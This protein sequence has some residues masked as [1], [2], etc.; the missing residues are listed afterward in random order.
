[1]MPSFFIA[2]GAP[3]LAIQN[4]DY[5]QFLGKLG[6]DLPKPDAIILF[7]AH[8]ENGT[9]RVSSV[10]SYETIYDFGGFPDE[11]YRIKY[12]AAG[13]S[14]TTDAIAEL[15]AK[16]GIPFQLDTQRGLDHG[17]W[18]VLRLLYPN[19]DIPVVAMSVNPLLSPE[20]QYEI[21]KALAELRERNVLIIGSGGTVHNLRMITWGSKTAD[22]WA[23]AFDEWL[24]AKVEAWDTA[25]LFRYASEA[26]HAGS[27]VPPRGNEHFVPL[28][29]A[30]G[31]ADAGRKA[32]LLHRSYEYGSLSHSV[33]RFE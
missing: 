31:A 5:T 28:F 18:V 11:M 21:G 13:S 12:P 15:F 9:Q 24:Q 27:A 20:A 23:V 22:E 14:S 33:W 17:A 2:H 4:N 29:Y 1:M 32:T 10:D 3:L 25:A 19:A 8:W 6:S 26:P 16:K 7:S 30:M